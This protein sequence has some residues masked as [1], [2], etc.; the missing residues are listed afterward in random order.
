MGLLGCP[1][2]FQRIVELAM[3][4]FINVIAYIVEILL[5]SRNHFEHR[6][7][8]EKLFYGLRDAGLKV[9]LSKSEF[10]AIN[11]K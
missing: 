3:K 1:A 11:V 8:L 2:L 10:G 5:H 7:Q 4:G 6:E 9:N